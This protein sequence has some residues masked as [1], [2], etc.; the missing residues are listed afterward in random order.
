MTVPAAWWLVSLQGGPRPAFISGLQDNPAK[1]NIRFSELRG[2]DLR[3]KKKSPISPSEL[4][5]IGR[6]VYPVPTYALT[7]L[8]ACHLPQPGALFWSVKAKRQ[9]TKYLSIS[10]QRGPCCQSS[11]AGR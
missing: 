6:S 10:Y 7:P 11:D 5:R 2:K 4:S 1:G 3:D 8:L 9:V